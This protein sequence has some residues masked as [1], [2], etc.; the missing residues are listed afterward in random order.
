MDETLST[1]PS[2]T[3]VATTERDAA[4]PAPTRS[5]RRWHKAL[6]VAAT[7][8]CVASVT[9]TQLIDRFAPGSPQDARAMEAALQA[10]FGD[11]E[12]TRIECRIADRVGAWWTGEIPATVTVR[13]WGEPSDP[14]GKSIYTCTFVLEDGAW[15]V[16]DLHTI[17]TAPSRLP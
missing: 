13:E 12:I 4:P 16:E 10:E 9:A 7:V 14:R 15:R 3:E 8:F 17:V 6:W 1:H 5:R 2:P 11:A